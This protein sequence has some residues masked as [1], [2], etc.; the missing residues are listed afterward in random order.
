MDVL[1]L[2][3]AIM[4]RQ[5]T[6]Q[7]KPRLFTKSNGTSL[8]PYMQEDI[9]LMMNH[10]NSYKRKALFGKSSLDLAKTVLPEDFFTL[11]GIEEIP[12]EKIILKPS[13]LDKKKNHLD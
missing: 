8:E 5:S 13:L 6:S 3:T 1:L 7:M 12:P 2:I 11:L 10:I 4:I 9:N